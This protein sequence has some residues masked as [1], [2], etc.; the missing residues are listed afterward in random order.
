MPQGLGP[1]AH[2][3]DSHHVSGVE[4]NYMGEVVPLFGKIQANR[5]NGG[6]IP[7]QP[8]PSPSQLEGELREEEPDIEE[9]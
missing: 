1:R 3:Y 2:G 7:T 5:I 4:K 9:D 8:Q 6:E